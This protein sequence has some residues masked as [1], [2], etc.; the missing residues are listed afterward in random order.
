MHSAIEYIDVN[1]IKPYQDINMNVQ[2]IE[3]ERLNLRQSYREY[4][5]ECVARINSGEC[6][7][8]VIKAFYEFKKEIRSQAQ[9]I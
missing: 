9:S 1:P 2:E 8:Q 6:S 5:E 7:Q 4:F 3:Q